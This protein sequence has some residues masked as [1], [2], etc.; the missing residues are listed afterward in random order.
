[1]SQTHIISPK[2]I[3]VDT[4]ASIASEN[5]KIKLSTQSI[6]KIENCRNYLDGKIANLAIWNKYLSDTEVDELIAG[7]APDAITNGTVGLYDYW[8]LEG[9]SLTGVNSN[10]L[11]VTGRECTIVS[12]HSKT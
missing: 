3:T 12:L 6:K 1:M 7:T 5:I 10:V 2:Q 4:L 11:A 8:S 9:S